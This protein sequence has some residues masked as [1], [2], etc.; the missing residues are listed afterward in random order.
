M[1][2]L[3]GKR[4]GK[5]I[6]LTAGFFAALLLLLLPANKAKADAR[7]MAN[8]VVFAV[9]AGDTDTTLQDGAGAVMAAYDS[10]FCSYFTTVSNG[11]MNVVNI[12][13]QNQN[14][15]VTPFVLSGTAES[16]TDSTAIVAEVAEQLRALNYPWSGV[17]N[18]E[19]DVVD[20]LT[21][22]VQTSA[23]LSRTDV[24]YPHKGISSDDTGLAG[25]GHLL[26]RSYNVI[27][28]Q[29]M[30]TTAYDGS[31][32]CQGIDVA[33]HEFFHSLGL[34]DLYPYN[35]STSMPVGPWC[36]MATGSLLRYPLSFLRAQLGW[37]PVTEVTT[38]GEITLN[39]ASAS[40]GTRLVK[41]TTTQNTAEAFYIEYRI[42]SPTVGAI[43]AKIPES[44]LLIYRVNDTVRDR[45]N[46]DDGN[47][48]YVFRP[49]NAVVNDT[50]T[51]SMP[52]PAYPTGN[53]MNNV[54]S[55]A[56][57]P[58]AGETGYGS[59]DLS[60]SPTEAD[61]IY[62]SDGTGSGI[63]I[64]DATLS[65]DGQSVTF[66]VTFGDTSSE[67]LWQLSGGANAG[68]SESSPD[69]C[70]HG[71]A[72]HIAGMRYTAATPTVW[73]KKQNGSAWDAVGA[74]IPNVFDPHLYSYNNTLYLLCCTNA[75]PAKARLYRL[76]GSTWTAVWTDAAENPQ[77]MRFVDGQSGL[78]YSYVTGTP[79]QLVVK[80][81][82][83]NTP[84]F[85]GPSATSFLANPAV[86]ERGGVFYIAYSD[87]G[88]SDSSGRI[89][90]Y[91]NGVL[92]A[93]FGL[94]GS[95]GANVH[96]IAYDGATLYALFG[97]STP[98][99]ATCQ[100]GTW[101][102][103]QVSA[104]PQNY[105]DMQLLASGGA[106]YILYTAAGTTVCLRQT[107]TGF[108]QHGERVFTG[109]D[110][111]RA[112]VSGGMI[113]IA[114]SASQSSAVTVR[115]KA[116]VAATPTPT[117][118]PTPT[119]TGS[120][121]TPTPTP[122]PTGSA[123]T[124]TPTAGTAYTFR[125]TPPA[126]YTDAYVW[127]DGVSHAAAREGGVYAVTLSDG[128]AK[129]AI[130]YKYNGS[131]PIGMYVYRLTYQN[132]AYTATPL[133]ALED[134]LT[135]HGFSIR[136]KGVSG[137]RFKTGILPATRAKLLSA[138]G[139]DGYRLIEYGTLVMRNSNRGT[140]PLILGGTRTSSGKAYW[141]ANGVVN[142]AIFET[143]DGRYRFTSVLVGLPA[144]EYRTEFAFRGYIIL[145][146]GGT[147]ITLYGPVMARSIYRIAEQVIASGEF[148]AGSA[149]D[150]YVRSI[151]ANAR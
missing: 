55:A 91:E 1:A 116:A 100:N 4:I 139:A 84:V 90:K 102:S 135:Y 46:R 26:V 2:N 136:V 33:I 124:P 127:V 76:D 87:Y 59:T 38:D 7:T 99:L 138:A 110:S 140:Y 57:N 131:I 58:A 6:A 65:G 77:Y 15:T 81:A 29:T 32:Y 119:G 105:T 96:D 42:Q 67:E 51:A 121:P 73:V 49:G 22:L 10:T 20:N 109:V 149:A 35:S 75:N 147:R 93:D 123:A 9:G 52:S 146:G 101:T 125:I 82:L 130:L 129:T 78:Y 118:T 12:F 5:R 24:L 92:T 56:V 134:L 50:E 88:S 120:T 36:V 48:I 74:E 132:G 11:A 13:P 72:L 142:D 60:L 23:D 150:R 86:C 62:Y 30:L 133:P 8:I 70:V 44:G 40:G 34:P 27:D 95:S 71:G 80:N 41:L 64:S 143:R 89:A 126:G 66:T 47:Y 145:E 103:T 19:A 85:Q 43:D 107:A 98:T 114:S 144:T 37:V 68:E 25:G 97:G 53:N 14:G 31:P 137:I 122:T 61:L 115:Q 17:C 69:P 45:T 79:D 111:V 148:A 3:F 113:Y 28:S 117:P 104:M 18:T 108:V 83:T 151:I 94:S 16:Y 106:P 21:V 54:N 128:S 39:A 112:T 63:A 141:K